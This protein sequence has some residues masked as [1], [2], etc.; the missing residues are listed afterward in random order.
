MDNR[1]EQSPKRRLKHDHHHLGR[2]GLRPQ[3]GDGGDRDGA[4]VMLA[5]GEDLFAKG[6]TERALRMWREVVELA[7]QRPRMWLRL[8][9]AM[10]ELGDRAAGIEYYRR[11]CAV[12]G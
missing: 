8:A 12:G 6:E 5:E 1:K 2:R 10:E 3:S 9:R 7:P 11:G 4:T